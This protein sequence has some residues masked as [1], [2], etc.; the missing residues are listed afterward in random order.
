MA[1]DGFVL[2]VLEES[3]T[4]RILLQ[5]FGKRRTRCGGEDLAFHGQHEHAMEGSRLAV[6]R[7]RLGVLLDAVLLVVVDQLGGDVQGTAGSEEM[8]GSESAG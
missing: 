7:G 2:G 1:P 4:W 3:L 5:S 8:T 6:N